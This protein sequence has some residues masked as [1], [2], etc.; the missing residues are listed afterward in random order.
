MEKAEK[1]EHSIDMF[2]H[3]LYDCSKVR[4]GCTGSSPWGGGGTGGRWISCCFKVLCQQC[5]YHHAVYT[6]LKVTVPFDR[7]QN[8]NSY[9]A[10]AQ[11]VSFPTCLLLVRVGSA[12]HFE[13]CSL[14]PYVKVI[15][16]ERRSGRDWV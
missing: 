1:V 14:L 11:A 7:E 4:T 15:L 10:L 6:R 2:C 5:Y 12:R 3:M 9:P 8:A 16:T 13:S